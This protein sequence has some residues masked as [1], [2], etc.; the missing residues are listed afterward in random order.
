V[1]IYAIILIIALAVGLLFVL[2]IRYRGSGRLLNRLTRRQLP[3]L[4]AL[5][6]AGIVLDKDMIIVGW[7]KGAQLT[8]GYTPDEAIG[9]D[10]TQL[11]REVP[12]TMFPEQS[13]E[14]LRR[15]EVWR[16]RFSCYSKGRELL[17]ISSICTPLKNR[18]GQV[19]GFVGLDQDITD[20][21]KLESQL[22]HQATLLGAVRDAVIA[23]DADH[24]I[25]E[26]N[27]AAEQLYGYR[28]AEAEGRPLVELLQTEKA[29]DFLGA[30]REGV[31]ERGIWQ[32]RLT[33][34]TRSGQRVTVSS[35]LSRLYDEEGKPSGFLAVDR[36]I[37]E[38]V[39]IERA[40][41][42]Q[43]VYLDSLNQTAL[44]LID[45]LNLDEL[46][47][48]VLNRATEL[49][50]AKDAIIYLLDQHSHEM[51]IRV[52]VGVGKSMV[53]IKVQPGEGIA[54]KVWW[55]GLSINVRD[56]SLWPERINNPLFADFHACIGLPLRAGGRVVGVLGLIYT[57][58][59]PFFD[60]DDEQILSRFAEL[61]SIALD[62][63]LLFQA[64]QNELSE[65]ARIEA[66]LT[67]LN[68]DLEQRVI[69][70]TQELR[71]QQRQ[72][73]AILDAMGEGVI[74]T[75]Q[76][77]I[78]YINRA[79]A[80]MT[81]YPIEE[82]IGQPRSLLMG[83]LLP[84]RKTDTN[85]FSAVVNQQTWRGTTI[86]RRKDGSEFEAA[87]TLTHL[88]GENSSDVLLVRDITEEKQLE[89]Q[90]SQ[91]IAN[92]S[93]ELRTPLTN[94][95]TRLYLIRRQ[96]ESAQEHMQVVERVTNRMSQLVDDLL[97]VARF[98]RGAI[99][100]TR[101]DLILQD[102]IREVVD[103]QNPE[104]LRKRITLTAKLI[105]QPLTISGDPD[106]LTQVIVNLA[107]NA[108]NYTP[109]GGKITV[110]L[111]RN[112]HDALL[113]IQDTGIGIAPENIARIFDP[114]FRASEGAV[115]GTGLGL[116]IAREIV[117]LH[118]GDITV[119]S[120]I[121]EGSTFLI[122]LPLKMPTPSRD[123]N[124]PQHAIK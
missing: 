81:A 7:N 93:H 48:T 62:N 91:F 13:R 94:I 17:T 44:A 47:E 28:S 21:V 14:Y 52:G 76:N 35:T 31:R 2:L 75:E 83:T 41:A 73:T 70:R 9:Q 20:Q 23:I 27:A 107:V 10:V 116:N 42:Q 124:S 25:I 46:L 87:L 4:E 43:N 24:I 55:G 118:G 61:A 5:P 95:K 112:E 50:E 97:D 18:S 36:D 51:K 58:S 1:D 104:A 117:R 32:G 82:L 121:R 115:R 3:L 34:I 102:V 114:F 37:S 26:W 38:Q 30:F 64:A 53:G 111:E 122:R 109:D 69:Q 19:L 119:Q 86:M 57:A 106:R 8:Y 45:R 29:I 54:G 113:S 120:Q 92:A 49:V 90:K 60:Q 63:S 39:A 22:V 89:N 6:I 78:R 59:E 105:E 84:R 88:S 98:E 77:Q 66:R 80:E 103:L 108:I 110:T 67:E 99:R 100:M 16:G 56:Y 101:Q 123:G 15:G 74:Y 85:Q 33:H 96:P 71:N 11:L 12:G 79:M 40:L 65:R 68:S 72:L